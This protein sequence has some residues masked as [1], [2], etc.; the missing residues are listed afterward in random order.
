[1]CAGVGWCA[2]GFVGMRGCLR[3][4]ASVRG[5]AQVCVG[6]RR[7]AQVCMENCGIHFYYISKYV[8]VCGHLHRCAGACMGVQCMQRYMHAWKILLKNV[9]NKSC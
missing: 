1:M 7:C 2:Q 6:V 3:V 8:G 4:C 9:F 5:S